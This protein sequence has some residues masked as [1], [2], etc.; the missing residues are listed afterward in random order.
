MV[1]T[2]HY[3]A[4]AAGY[5]I[6]EEGGNAIDAGIAAGMVLGVTLP[7]WVSLGGV[8]PI[9]IYSAE[10]NEVKA[11]SGLGRWPKAARLDR[12]D[13]LDHATYFPISFVFTLVGI[14]YFESLLF[15][16]SSLSCSSSSQR[17]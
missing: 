10:K 7:Q 5:R 17:A 12:L 1:A 2:G 14:L 8:A 6:L 13:R 3:L 15:S 11:I 16:P 9:L 4:S